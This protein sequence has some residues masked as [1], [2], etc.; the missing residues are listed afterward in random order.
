[1]TRAVDP[2]DDALSDLRI[3]GS[4]LL[5]EA[6]SPPWTIEVPNEARLRKTLNVGPDVRV[7]PFHLVRRGGFSLHIQ[8]AK[9]MQVAAPE[10]CICPSGHAHRL[11]V[12]RGGQVTALDAIL[13][14]HGPRP[15]H[16]RDATATE[17]VCGVFMARAA[18]LSPMLGAL[19]SVVKVSTGDE[20]RYPSLAGAVSLLLA[21]LSRGAGGGFTVSRLLEIFCAE[22]F[23]AQTLATEDTTP[24]WFRGLAD[25]RIGEA[26]RAIHTDPGRAWTVDSL[27]SLVALSPSRFAARFRETTGDS[28]MRYVAVWRANVA[29]RLL[30]EPDLSLSEVANRVGYESLPAFSRAFKEQLGVPPAAFRASTSRKRDPSAPVG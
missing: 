12:G 6:Y 16:A 19:P 25:P 14:G 2:F 15:A 29:C 17:L 10:V 24:S 9:P 23:R 11:S 27:A 18:P 3:S 20:A 4:V 8:G 5:C 28:V 21:E 7:L 1:M 13:S 30:R 22:A 26:L